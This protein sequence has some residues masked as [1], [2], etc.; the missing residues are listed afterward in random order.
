MTIYYVANS[1]K[2]CENVDQAV[3]HALVDMGVNY[4]QHHNDRYNVSKPMI[5]KARGNCFVVV[6]IYDSAFNK[7]RI[8]KRRIDVVNTLKSKWIDPVEYLGKID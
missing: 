1:R 6:S 4:Y 3:A 7:L 5:V 2:I 8:R